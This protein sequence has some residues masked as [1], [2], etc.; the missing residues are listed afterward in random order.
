MR[1]VYEISGTTI[2]ITTFTL[3]GSQK[4]KQRRDWKCIW[5]NDKW[6]LPKL[7]KGNTYP[8]TKSMCMHASS[9][10]SGPTLCEPMNCSPPGSSLHG[11]SP[12]KNTGV[13]L[14]CPPS[15][16]LPN[17]GIKPVSLRS[18]ALAGGFL[19]SSATWQACVSHEIVISCMWQ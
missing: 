4:E 9:L 6:K 11:D 8:G 2:S 12:G 13:G 16:D 10:Q 15:G 1:T 18:P 17:P 3:Y 5:G 14:P 19:N 7:E